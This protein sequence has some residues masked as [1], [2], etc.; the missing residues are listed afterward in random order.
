MQK[1]IRVFLVLLTT[2]SLALAM[3]GCGSQNSSQDV[4]VT[5]ATA[6]RQEL[7]SRLEFSGILV[8]AQTVDIASKIS[9]QVTA[10]GFRVGQPVKAGDVLIRV[11]T[12][13]LNGQLLAAQATLQGAQAAAETAQNQ[14]AISQI[15]LAAAQINYDQ[16]KALFDAGALSQNQLNDAQDKFNIASQQYA[17]A[18]G[19]AQAQATA[20]I[21]SAYANIKNLSCLL[22]TS[23]SPRDGLLSRMPSSA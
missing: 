1:R 9:G 3:A 2:L 20:A 21:N 10:L 14:A 7:E 16:T 13:A 8:P 15:N 4:T 23:P 17:T 5:T 6:N 22:Y 19:P 18:S 12:E 11:D